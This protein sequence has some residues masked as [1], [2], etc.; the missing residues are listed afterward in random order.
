MT[1]YVF[2]EIVDKVETAYKLLGEGKIVLPPRNFTKTRDGGDYLYCAA[3]NLQNQ[4][5]IVLGS[6]FMPWNKDRE[7]PIVV[8]SYL[9]SSF[10]NG[11]VLAIIEGTHIVNLRTAAK[12]A[13]AIKLLAKKES[14][15]LGFIGLGQQAKM[16]AEIISKYF[17]FDRI[18]AFSRNPQNYPEPQEYIKK[19]TG[20]KVEVLPIS[21]IAKL[22]D[23]IIVA[24]H[25]K[26]PLI[27]FSDLNPGQLI[28]SLDHAES[29]SRDIV[30]NAK[31]YV[32]YR[33]TAENELGPVKL[34]IQENGYKLDQIAGDLSEVIL[35]TKKGR[36]ND[37]EIIYF[38]S[39]GVT[40][41]NLATV[42]YFYEKLKDETTEIDLIG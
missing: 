20:I 39:L 9:Y 32:D 1:N 10:D 38:Q 23:I 29:V 26:E 24:T 14:K 31:T 17:K 25:A 35:G 13:V 7:L 19:A 41:E 36:E 30:T 28:V 40:H 22:A 27:N 37:S 3:T 18:I 6:A 5:F 42:E 4:T 2:T 33:P 15:I 11:D 34:S 21:E 12:S 8:G 16:H